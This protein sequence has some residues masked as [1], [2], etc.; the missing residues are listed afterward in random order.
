MTLAVVFRREAQLDFASSPTS[1]TTCSKNLES[2]YS[3]FFMHAAIRPVGARANERPVRGRAGGLSNRRVVMPNPR[4]TANYD[5]G[6]DLYFDPVSNRLFNLAGNV[7]DA[8]ANAELTRISLA[9]NSMTSGSCGT[10]A[11][12]RVTDP[13]TGK[14]YWVGQG[15]RQDALGVSAYARNGLANLGAVDFGMPEELG[16]LG[17]PADLSRL[18]GNRLAFVTSRG[19][20]VLL[21]SSLLAP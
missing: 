5:M 2:S 19:Y 14:L 8:T 9:H 11:Q 16:S 10:S 18:P 21:E 1:S 17:L 3:R 13:T 7:F 4:I 15:I 6:R 12:T 20:L